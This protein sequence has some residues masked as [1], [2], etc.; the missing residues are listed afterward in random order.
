MTRFGT[1]LK[2]QREA[3]RAADV[4]LHGLA[5]DASRMTEYAE[6]YLAEGRR[7]LIRVQPHIPLP[8][9]AEETARVAWEEGRDAVVDC[10]AECL[11]ALSHV[12]VAMGC[13]DDELSG[14]YGKSDTTDQTDDETAADGTTDDVS[15]S[16]VEEK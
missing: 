8:T 14:R 4:D 12:L 7:A 9:A 11:S 16:D 5:C 13:T 1:W 15:E 3:D 2:D 6:K 10:I